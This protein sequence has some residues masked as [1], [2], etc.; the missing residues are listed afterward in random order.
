MHGGVVN[1]NLGGKGA[2]SDQVYVLSLPA[3]HW[4]QA[5]YSSAFPR[6]G[7]TCHATKT[8]QMIL[9]GGTN[10]LY[11]RGYLGDGVGGEPS[12]PWE[13]GIA[14]FDM[15]ALK[16]KDSYQAKSDPYEPP[17]VVLQFYR[18]R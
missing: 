12:D 14:V 9:I 10:P 2:K 5:N 6:G 18:N 17:D 16:F 8:N 3:F 13:Q 11:S 7:H 15:T 1:Y 4:F